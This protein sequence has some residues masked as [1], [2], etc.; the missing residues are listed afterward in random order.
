MAL[1]ARWWVADYYFKVGAYGAAEND[2][3]VIAL[4]WPESAAHWQALMMAGR[5]AVARQAWTDA[6]DYFLN[7][8]AGKTNCPTQLHFQALY[9]YGDTLMSGQTS[10]N[11]LEDYRNAK[12]YFEKICQE[13]ST[14]TLG[15]LACG[16]RANCLL[17][18]AQSGEDLAVAADAF[19]EILTTTNSS[20]ADASTRSIAKV[21]LGIVLEKQAADPATTDPAELRNQA[22]DQYLDVLFGKF[23]RENEVAD[24]WWM[25]KAGR[26]A[27]RL[28]GE[29]QQWAKVVKICESLAAKL[30]KLG[31]SLEDQRRRA[32][33]NLSH[34][35]Q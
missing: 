19:K 32:L 18:L 15:L 20:L 7:K 11:K 28:A 26:E 10:T 3:Q 8:I 6:A 14:N 31:P 4:N 30:P 16:Q 35:K 9:A 17:Q 13:Y 29:M 27:L 5:A 25:R 21:G 22:L 23:V 33:E 2:Y 1:E 34:P 12:R 24:E